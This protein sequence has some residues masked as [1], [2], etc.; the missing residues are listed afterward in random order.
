MVTLE[1]AKQGAIYHGLATL[2]N[3]PSPMM[4]RSKSPPPPLTAASRSSRLLI[5]CRVPGF[6][7]VA[8]SSNTHR[9]CGIGP[10]VVTTPVLKKDA[11]L[12]AVP[13]ITRS[14]AAGP[15]HTPGDCRGPRMFHMPAALG[16]ALGRS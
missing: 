2:L 7:P 3:Q 1:V 10:V 4:Q 13:R 5:A 15:S 11:R 12:S 8:A 16:A 9:P 6:F 14:W